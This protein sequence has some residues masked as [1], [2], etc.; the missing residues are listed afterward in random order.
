[1]EK[2][3]LIGGILAFVSAWVAILLMMKWLRHASF[4]PF[5]LYRLALGALLLFIAYA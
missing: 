3:A 4:L 5:V 2:D 1:M